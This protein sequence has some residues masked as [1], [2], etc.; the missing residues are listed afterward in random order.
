MG[1][2]TTPADQVPGVTTVIDTANAT[3]QVVKLLAAYFNDKA[4]RDVDASTA[5]FNEEPVRLRRRH[6]G[7][8]VPVP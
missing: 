3:P 8:P 6:P 4:R 7:R 1:N 2:A 5:N